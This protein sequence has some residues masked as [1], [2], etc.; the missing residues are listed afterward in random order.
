MKQ[1]IVMAAVLPLLMIFVMQFSLE[2]Q[3]QN[4][5]AAFQEIVYSIKEQ[6][7]QEG[8]F[9]PA[10]KTALASAAAKCFEVDESE[11][12]IEADS[13]IKYRRNTFDERELIHYK[14]KAPIKKIMAG[15]R[16]LG[17]SDDANSGWYV[18]EGSAASE[19]LRDE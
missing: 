6:A 3:N 4:R 14:V 8:R 10:M 13:D 16:L 11:I 12:I 17:I 18:I 19:K 5:I 9:T 1:F 7:R 2:Q 15:N